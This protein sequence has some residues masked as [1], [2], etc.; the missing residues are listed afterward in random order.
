MK[1]QRKHWTA[2]GKA[3][4]LREHLID[5]APISDLCDKHGFHPTLLYRW[6]KDLFEHAAVAFQGNGEPS[7]EKA[8]ERKVALLEEKLAHKDEVIAEIMHD[9]VALKKK[10]GLS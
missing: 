6:Q 7:R 5:K 4:I 8:L 3:A 1:R 9:Y 2:E 10:L